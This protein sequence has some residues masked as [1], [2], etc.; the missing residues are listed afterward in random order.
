MISDQW[1][2]QR[3]K[4]AKSEKGIFSMTT[5]TK[6]LR[7]CL[8]DTGVTF[9]PARSKNSHVGATH[10]GASSPWLLHRSENFV[11]ARN[12]ETVSCKRLTTTRSSVKSTY[13]WAGT[14]SACVLSL[15]KSTY[16]QFG[17]TRVFYQRVVSLHVNTI[18]T[19]GITRYEIKKSLR[20]ETR[21][22]ASFLM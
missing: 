8:H 12:L 18:R 3:Q 2:L 7:G 17:F 16:L 21:A 15:S 13:L 5:Q 1:I 14:S 11:P 20:C 4:N 10:T 19:H 22:G 9:A 6:K